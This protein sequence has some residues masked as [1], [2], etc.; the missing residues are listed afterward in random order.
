MAT[1]TPCRFAGAKRSA[2]EPASAAESSAGYPL[3]SA[4]RVDSGSSFPVESTNRRSITSPST[5]CSNNVGGY[6][7]GTWGLSAT[8]AS[9]SGGAA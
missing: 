4:T 6:A 9:D 8:G 1:A 2:V 5:R 3:V 7:I